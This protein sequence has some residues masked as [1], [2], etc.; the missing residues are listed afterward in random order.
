MS[1]TVRLE[2]LRKTFG[3]KT[4]IEDISTTLPPGKTS[5]L[6]GPSGCGKSTLLRMIVG[7]L[8]PDSGKIYCD[9]LE[10][11][12]L[13]NAQL[14]EFRNRIGIVFQLSALFD[15]MTVGENVGF[16]LTQHTKMSRA[17][18]DHI[19]AEKLRIVGLEG[20]AKL[21]PS[22]ISGGMQRR[23]SFARAIVRNPELI[24]F[25]EP[26]TGLDPQMS[27]VIE[28]L[29][30]RISDETGATSI[31]VTHQLSTIFRTADHIAML[32]KGRLVGEGPPEEMRQSNNP[33]IRDFLEGRVNESPLD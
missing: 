3:T 20:T 10:I 4:V 1:I 15:S 32:Y 12:S 9:D 18:I 6:I 5:V 26:T 33:L 8:Q 29:M 2:N 14:T 7:L 28:D 23:V 13:K 27:T 19:V 16:P 31:V 17:E 22:E 21:Y 11:T 30:N 24:F 25:D